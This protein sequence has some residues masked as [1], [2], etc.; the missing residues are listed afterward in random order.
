MCVLSCTFAMLFFIIV[1]IT[2]NNT[3]KAYL[4][5]IVIVSSSVVNSSNIIIITSHFFIE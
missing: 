2:C 5:I 4:F 1:K 3:Y